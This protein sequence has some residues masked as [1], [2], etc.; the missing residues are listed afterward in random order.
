M[1]KEFI[2][3]KNYYREWREKGSFCPAFKK[4]I[5]ISQM[6]WNHIIGTK[7]HSRTFKDISRRLCLLEDARYILELTT[8]FQDL[9]KNNGKMFIAIEAIIEKDDSI[10]KVRVI[11]KK[12]KQSNYIFYSVMGK[13][14]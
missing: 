6:G 11:L 14:I 13:E 7:G 1:H 3:Y 9:R 4:S 10:K 5:V 2:S 8:T 12:D